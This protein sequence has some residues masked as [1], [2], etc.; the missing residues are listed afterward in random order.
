MDDDGRRASQRSAAAAKSLTT[1]RMGENDMVEN[2]IVRSDEVRYNAI[3]GHKYAGGD[4][5]P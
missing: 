2:T 1:G 4:D 5:G 3:H